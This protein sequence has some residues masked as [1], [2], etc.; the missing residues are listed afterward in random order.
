MAKKADKIFL[1]GNIITMNRDNAIV[2]AVAI[3]GSSILAAGTNEEILH[4][5]DADAEVVDLRGKTMMPA[6]ID[7]HSHVYNNAL[8]IVA[9]ANLNSPPIGDKTCIQDI[10][11]ELKKRAKAMPAGTL[12]K[13][14]GYDDTALLEKRRI[15]RR[16]LDSVS[17]DHPIIIRH[18]TGHLHFLNSSALAML[19][20]TKDTPNPPDGVYC[21]DASSGELTGIVEEHSNYFQQ[22]LGQISPEE[23]LLAVKTASDLY[24]QKGIAL[25]ST[26]ATRSK[27]EMDLLHEGIQSGDFKIRVIFN[28]VTQFIEERGARVYNDYFMKGSAKNFYDGSIQG[29][30]GYLSKPYHTP[31]QGDASYRGYSAMPKEELFQIVQETH[32]RGEQ[33][34]VHCNGDQAIEDM[35]DACEAAQKKNPRL[36][37]RHVVIHA[38]MAR[39]DQLERMKELGVLPSFFILHTYYWGDRHT[40]IFMGPERANRMS[41]LKS[42]LT[43]EIP[44]TIHCDTPVVP[45]EPMRAVWSAVNRISSSGKQIGGE[46]RIGVMDA[47]RAY[48]Y[49]AAYQYFLEDKTGSVEP[50][51]WADLIVLDRDPLTCPPMELKDIEVLET[52]V[53]GTSVYQK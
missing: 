13:G 19:G 17:A 33:I 26:G 24:M 22:L 8:R 14:F 29:Y 48:T 41:P 35:L 9:E 32:D 1:N 38:Q 5:T 40:D 12:V 53:G 4:T 30:T 18:I 52:I 16:D 51:K 46:Q 2:S 21:R 3:R 50:N 6:F 37:P 42:A 45:Q 28:F 7:S 25:A 20:I 39:E 11:D 47:L 10:L 15:D 43:K 49:N 27:R 23:E 44:F 31:Y 36:D 34:F